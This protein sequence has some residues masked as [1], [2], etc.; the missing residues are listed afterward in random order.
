MGHIV[1]PASCSL[2]L[3]LASG[4]AWQAF[5]CL[6]LWSLFMILFQRYMHLRTVKRCFFT[7]ERLDELVL[8]AW[9]APL[10]MILSASCFWSA[11]ERGWP[12][13][14]V[15]ISW[16]A[17]WSIYGLVLA[18]CVW[19]QEIAQADDD[20]D[21]PNYNEV[22]AR[23]FYDWHNCNPI[24]V[25]LSHCVDECGPPLTPYEV[26]KG[27]LQVKG[28]DL[29]SKMSRMRSMIY[30]KQ[31][32][33]NEPQVAEIEGLLESATDVGSM[34]CHGSR[35][36]RSPCCGEKCGNAGTD[37]VN[38]SMPADG[39]IFQPAII[40]RITEVVEEPIVWGLQENEEPLGMTYDPAAPQ[41]GPSL[42]SPATR[43][44][45]GRGSRAQES[46]GTP[47]REST[48]EER[49]DPVEPKGF[50]APTS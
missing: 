3:F 26:G 33:S 8:I 24:R 15:P 47:S 14:V 1:Q 35:L 28:V 45:R 37:Q 6:A 7:T 4:V 41:A 10:S 25:L 19:P 5:L 9:G 39:A 34:F 44:P 13:F 36:L 48:K 12:M 17:A 46:P 32:Q 50:D 22:R 49:T 29:H 42:F 11:K 16:L 18:F 30:L 2:S 31:G 21:T 23:R 27:Y 43:V 20:E 40:H 38:E